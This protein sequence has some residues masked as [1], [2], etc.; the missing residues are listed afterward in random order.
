MLQMNEAATFLNKL[1]KA[2]GD[3]ITLWQVDLDE[4][5]DKDGMAACV[6]ATD[7]KE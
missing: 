5:F 3:D 1:R 7:F 2:N 6:F 4:P